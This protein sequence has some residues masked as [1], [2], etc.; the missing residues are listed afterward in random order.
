MTWIHRPPDGGPSWPAD[1][2]RLRWAG[3][4]VA[5][6]TD[7]ELI[8]GTVNQVRE[9]AIDLDTPKGRRSVG[10]ARVVAVAICASLSDA[11]ELIGAVL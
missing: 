6:K 10:V 11:M 9:D 8:A 4:G 2:L 7:D 5:L 3:I 1:E